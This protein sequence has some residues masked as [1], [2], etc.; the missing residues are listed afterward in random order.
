MKDII[1]VVIVFM[2]IGWVVESILY[3]PRNQCSKIMKNWSPEHFCIFPFILTYGFAVG[4]LVLLDRSRFLPAHI[5]L[6][7]AIIGTLFVVME[8]IEVWA[9]CRVEN[10]IRTGIYRPQ[11]ILSFAFEEDVQ[12]PWSNDV[13]RVI[14]YG[15]IGEILLRFMVDPV[16]HSQPSTII[17]WMVVSYAVIGS[18]RWAFHLRYPSRHG[19]EC[20]E[21]N[22][23]LTHV[24]C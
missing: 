22:A 6:R 4:T 2:F 19:N 5:P 24:P 23:H 21:C 12:Y 3:F 16:I 9:C 1:Q 17:F 8:A 18:L 7:I 11:A 10:H 15:T 20:P 13:L 14:V